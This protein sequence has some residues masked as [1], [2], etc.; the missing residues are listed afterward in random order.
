MKE[1]NL[2]FDSGITRIGGNPYGQEIYAAQIKEK[3]DFNDIN[4]IIFPDIVNGVSISFV[5]GLMSEIVN[6][7]GKE[8][9][10]KHFILYSSN[11][12]VNDKLQKSIDYR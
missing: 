11:N 5:Q 2:K 4:K 10:K 1:I 3:A 6:D 9:F 7:K 8:Y 12:T